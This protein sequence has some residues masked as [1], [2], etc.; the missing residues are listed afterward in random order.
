[1]Y[2]EVYIDAVFVVNLFLNLL[3]LQILCKV[4][5]C[6]ATH[7]RLFAGAITGAFCQ[8]I[9]ILLGIGSIWIKFFT[10]CF[11]VGMLMIH[12]GLRIKKLHF[13]LVYTIVMLMINMI[14]AGGVEFI[15]HGIIY[16]FPQSQNI[17]EIIGIF[18]VMGWTLLG[19]LGR[20]RSHQTS[21]YRVILSEN[22]ICREVQ[23]LMDTGNGLRDPIYGRPV[24]II[25]SSVVEQM[26]P[27][28]E[29]P[30]FCVIPYHSIGKKSGMMQGFLLQDVCIIGNM[31][32]KN[33]HQLMVG[34][35][36]GKLSSD[37]QYQMILHPKLLEN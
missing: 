34:I 6:T 33:V 2:Y 7:T 25:E 19:A 3:S 10:T 15:R 27:Y 23:A 11:A 14:L 1:M 22:G 5:K 37:N 32:E 16:F 9:L 26:Q 17:V 21:L 31:K 30:G 20:A 29:Q 24:S 4:L 35:Y 13:L 12:I 18:Y 28:E 36:Q 8:C